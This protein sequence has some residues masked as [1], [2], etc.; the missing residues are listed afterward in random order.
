MRQEVRTEFA[1]REGTRI[2]YR[3]FGTGSRDLVIV[4]GIISHVEY[5]HE[6]PGYDEF[7]DYVAPHFRVIIF[8]K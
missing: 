8:D 4:P 2:A 3:I 7:S 1:E 5:A 6:L